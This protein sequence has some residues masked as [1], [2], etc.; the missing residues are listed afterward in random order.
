MANKIFKGLLLIATPS[1]LHRPVR[2]PG[3]S[4][5]LPVRGL[6]CVKKPPAA[7]ESITKQEIK[8]KSR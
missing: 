1:L 2:E 5:A 6:G 7:A 4:G 8:I 3:S